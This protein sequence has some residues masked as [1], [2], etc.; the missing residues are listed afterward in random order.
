MDSQIGVAVL[1]LAKVLQS[2]GLTITTAESCT[3]GLIAKSLTDLSGSSSWFSQAWITYSNEA[4][5]QMLGVSEAVLEQ[6]GAVSAA[7]VEAMAKGASSRSG[8]SIAVAVSGIAGP[9]GA[10]PGKPVGTVWI[11]WASATGVTSQKYLF[12]GDR[13]SVRAQATLA[14]VL[15]SVK[16]G[17]SVPEAVL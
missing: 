12:A 1:K 6:H 16:L 15:E 3:G 8:A 11:A 17:D 4:K 2:R 9:G 13:Q 10:T 14:A 7:V 5:G